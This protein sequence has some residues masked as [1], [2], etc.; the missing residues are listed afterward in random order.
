MAKI[1]DLNCQI[2]IP[3]V[4][5]VQEACTSAARRQW[6]LSTAVGERVRR[7][8]PKPAALGAPH[9]CSPQTGRWGVEVVITAPRWEGFVVNDGRAIRLNWCVSGTA[10]VYLAKQA[11]RILTKSGV[12]HRR[13][14]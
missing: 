1:L 3:P 10:K 7:V 4:E 8:F 13:I 2:V 12:P 14:H 9:R 11:V 6:T 5:V